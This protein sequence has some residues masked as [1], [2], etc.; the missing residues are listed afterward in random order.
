MRRIRLLRGSISFMRRMI[1]EALRRRKTGRKADLFF[2]R[3]QVHTQHVPVRKKPSQG[4]SED[5]AIL[6]S[7]SAAAGGDRQSSHGGR[8]QEGR[9]G[10]GLPAAS[11]ARGPG[12]AQE[13]GR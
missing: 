8:R 3:V 13:A 2:R 4:R 6:D 10:T 11:E 1:I 9:K 5:V 7:R 12:Q